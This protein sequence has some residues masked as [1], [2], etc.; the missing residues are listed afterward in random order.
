M[1]FAFPWSSCRQ[2]RAEELR[3]SKPDR[4]GGVS[5]WQ[6]GNHGKNQHPGNTRVARRE[7]SKE[8]GGVE[9]R[10]TA[11]MGGPIGYDLSIF[12]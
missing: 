7:A 5:Q 3:D 2:I 8:K 12:E 4:T 6:K 9:R 1:K 10:K 11:K